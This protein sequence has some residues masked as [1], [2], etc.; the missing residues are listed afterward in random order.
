IAG[1]PGSAR[2]NS[3]NLLPG[4]HYSYANVNGWRPFQCHTLRGA[5]PDT[6]EGRYIGARATLFARQHHWP[7]HA[8]PGP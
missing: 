3:L 6:L 7:G 4:N 2:P 1:P 5:I 8:P